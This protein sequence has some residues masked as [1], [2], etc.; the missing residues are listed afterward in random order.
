VGDLFRRPATL[1]RPLPIEGC[2]LA[3]LTCVG[4][5]GDAVAAIS[6]TDG[7]VFSLE[8]DTLE[9]TATGLLTTETRRLDDVSLSIRYAGTDLVV[10]ETRVGHPEDYE[11]SGFAD[12]W[13]RYLASDGREP[14][15]AVVHLDV[16]L[17]TADRR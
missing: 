16:R 5:G 7:R 12:E 14:L 9:I 11:N 2:G 4:H 6:L 15:R 17:S 13:E 1:W 8:V 3:E 10:Q